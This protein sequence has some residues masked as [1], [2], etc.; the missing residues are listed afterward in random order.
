MQEFKTVAVLGAGAI[1]SYLIWGLSEK[2]GDNLWVV[3]D[4]ER[5]ERLAAK[6][7]NINDKNY[8][9]NVMSPAAANGVD[10]LFVTVKYGALEAALDDVAQICDEHT[11]VVSLMNGVDSEERIAERIGEE[12]V[13]YSLIKINSARKGDCVTFNPETTV[14][15]IY[16][17]KDGTLGTERLQAMETLFAGTPLHTKVTDKVL[18]EIWNKFAMNVSSNQPQAI[19]GVGAGAYTDS[20]H[21]AYL[22]EQL[23]NEVVAVASAKGIDMSAATG[24]GTPVKPQA[25]YS[26][27]QDLDAGRHTEVDMFA[28]AMIRMGKETG[29]P[30]PFNEVIYHLIK[31]LEE[32]NDGKFDYN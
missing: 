10:L 20:E 23:K 16:G 25:R 17:E 11:T 14:G 8:K 13:L 6:G 26:T 22:R 4:G 3:A 5:A 30:T 28:G 31:T 32:K 1:G 7:V 19:A 27:L 15:I 18:F 24:K 29:V 2:L 12:N 21:M 9:L